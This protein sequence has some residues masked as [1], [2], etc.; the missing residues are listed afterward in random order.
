MRD[1]WEKKCV[2]WKN[3]KEEKHGEIGKQKLK[4]IKKVK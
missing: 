2:L 4:K 1:R 3:L